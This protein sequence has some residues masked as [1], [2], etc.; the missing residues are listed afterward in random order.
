MGYGLRHSF[1][2]FLSVA[3]TAGGDKVQHKHHLQYQKRIKKPVT[4]TR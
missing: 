2:T 1:G 4:A 3:L